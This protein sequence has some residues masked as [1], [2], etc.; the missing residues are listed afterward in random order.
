MRLCLKYSGVP[1]A[2]PVNRLPYMA[3]SWR[4]NQTGPPGERPA[5]ITRCRDDVKVAL[6]ER[7]AG[8]L[9]NQRQDP[10]RTLTGTGGHLLTA[11]CG[12]RDNPSH[13]V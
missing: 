6:A 7:C 8:M 5:T 1:R 3:E 11:R 10:Y 4:G 2:A 9:R 12:R 13:F